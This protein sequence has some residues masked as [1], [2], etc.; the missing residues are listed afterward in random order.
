MREGDKVDKLNE[1]SPRFVLYQM[2]RNMNRRLFFMFLTTLAKTPKWELRQV[3]PQINVVNAFKSSVKK[4]SQGN[5]TTVPTW[6]LSV[7]K[8]AEPETPSAPAPIEIKVE[9]SE[10][11]KKKQ[12]DAQREDGQRRKR[13]EEVEDSDADEEGKDLKVRMRSKREEE[14][15][16]DRM[17]ESCRNWAT[18]RGR[19]GNQHKW[20]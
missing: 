10:C 7:A 13:P 8:R 15:K 6:K 9:E 12:E 3:I 18:A 11:F 14:R 17:Y 5:S 4:K 19:I 20:K 2:S 1:H 16:K